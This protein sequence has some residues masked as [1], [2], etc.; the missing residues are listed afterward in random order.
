MTVALSRHRRLV[1]ALLAALA[2]AFGLAA[3]RPHTRGV[4]VPVAARDLAG[5]VVLGPRDVVTR[6]FPGQAVPA[7]ILTRAV[8]RTLSGPV[9]RGEPLTDSRV[10]SGGLFDGHDP[11]MVAVPVRLADA[12]VARLLRAGDRVDV[13]AA[14]AEGPL[15]ARTVAAAVPVIAVPK[16]GM[17]T[18]EGALVVLRTGR[19]Q[20]AALAR[21]SVDSRLSVTILG[22]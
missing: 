20:A 6:L 13:L 17:E 15:P 21:V 12:A 11:A 16:P 1:A 3:A 2:A 8:G 4:R 22:D 10:R 19:E 9:R 7:G 5:G 14:R 18:G